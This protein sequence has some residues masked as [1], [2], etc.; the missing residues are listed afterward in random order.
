MS[1]TTA[2]VCLVG[3]VLFAALIG[4]ALYYKGTVRAGGRF[5]AA[6]FYIEAQDRKH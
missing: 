3:T 2:V 6:E 1:T 4:C 5:K